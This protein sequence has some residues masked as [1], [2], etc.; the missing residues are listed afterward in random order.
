M[1]DVLYICTRTPKY[2]TKIIKI[3]SPKEEHP[4]NK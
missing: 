2:K 4:E 1:I 3:H